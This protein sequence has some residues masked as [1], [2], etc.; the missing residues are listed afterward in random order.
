MNTTILLIFQI[1]VAA[2]T[3]YL[4]YYAREKGKNQASK[5]DLKELTKI[6][7]DVKKENLKELELLKAN[8]LVFTDKE[9]QIFSEEKEAI[10]IFFAQL[11]NW[12]W[13]SLNIYIYEYNH[14]NYQEIASRLI[15]MRDN[16]N[17][18]NVTFSK[19]KLIVDDEDLI[20]A[21]HDAISKTLKLHHFVESLLKR[22]SSNL[23]WE[24]IMVDRVL[25]KEID[26]QTLASSTQN[27]YKTEAKNN[28]EERKLITDEY[29]NQH[30][31]SFN[32]A[33]DSVN[34]FKTISKKYL[35]K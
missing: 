23:G 34:N 14:S 12:I 32:P 33:M 2:L 24:K 31:K 30:E 11:N 15:L 20:T 16:Y 1:L 29:F 5:D 22:L 28:T 9:K 17:K 13:D 10:I 21:G 18:T 7:E 27:Y 8:L 3:A 35:R 4:I 26:F 25:N 6:V 19:V